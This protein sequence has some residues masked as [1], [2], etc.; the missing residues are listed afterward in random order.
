MTQAHTQ[1]ALGYLT[2]RQLP[3]AAAA[4]LRVV[5]LVVKWEERRRTRRGLKRLDAHLLNDIGLS[6]R[7]VERELARPVWED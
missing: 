6:R 5:V 2:G 4:A 3:P 1:T 7:D